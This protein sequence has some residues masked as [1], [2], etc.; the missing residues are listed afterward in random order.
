MLKKNCKFEV[1]NIVC[2]K[3]YAIR[4]ISDLDTQLLF[5]KKRQLNYI[6]LIE[7]T[8]A[9]FKQNCYQKIK[10]DKRKPLPLLK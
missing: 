9:I 7:K 10:L 6:N 8:I 4:Q 2:K 1:E 5:E 3:M